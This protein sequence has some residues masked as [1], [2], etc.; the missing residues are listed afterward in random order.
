MTAGI[1][2]PGHEKKGG[3]RLGHKHRTTEMIHRIMDVVENDLYDEQAGVSA[4]YNDLA[5]MSPKERRDVMLKLLKIVM[6]TFTSVS[7]ED[8]KNVSTI[9]QLMEN[10]AAYNKQ[11]EE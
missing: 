3:K 11:K 6:P 8:N 1:F 10:M 5:Q 4:F 9:R 7:I 2:Q